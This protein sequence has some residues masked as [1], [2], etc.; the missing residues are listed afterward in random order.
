MT[1]FFIIIFNII[2][3][4]FIKRKEIK[5]IFY[6][7]KIGE[8]DVQEIHPIFQPKRS[9]YKFPSEKY[10]TN[11]FIIPEEFKVIGMTSNLEAWILCMLSKIS[12]NIFEFGTC[13]GKTTY[14]FALN[15]SPETKI[16]SI[17]L[18]SDALITKN[19]NESKS[20]YRNISNESIYEEFMFT[21]TP[22]QKKIDV[23]FINSLEFD[24]TEFTNKCDLIFIDGGHTYSIVK[25]DT[26]KAFKM[27]SKNGYIFWH[28]YAPGKK[29]AKDVFNY[30]NL[31]SRNKK[32]YSIKDTNLVYFK[33][34]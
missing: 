26:E 33:N 25:S 28:D 2:F 17:T 5:K 23:R 3:I 22:Y 27:I 1:Y 31:I 32:L 21:G 7:K 6:K 10:V 9:K 8:V 34:D 11:F 19:K 30:L 14:L 20:A 24:E 15:S 29:S 16:T 12:K 18:K 4:Y 13:S